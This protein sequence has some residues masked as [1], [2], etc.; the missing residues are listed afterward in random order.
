MLRNERRNVSL[1]WPVPLNTFLQVIKNMPPDL[2][3]SA[4]FGG[5]FEARLVP[6]A[7]L[8]ASAMASYVPLSRL[9]GV[10]VTVAH[11][12]DGGNT[13]RRSHFSPTSPSI[14]AG[15]ISLTKSDTTYRTPGCPRPEATALANLI[16]GSLGV[17][18]MVQPTQRIK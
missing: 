1:N 8:S 11:S 6:S 2:S 13:D 14:G 18:Q 10:L 5:Y 16:E 7:A 9:Q 4:T 17:D 3:A 15:A 12:E